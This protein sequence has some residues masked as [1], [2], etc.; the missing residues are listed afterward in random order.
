[1]GL[2][3]A[4][5]GI[6]VSMLFYLLLFTVNSFSYGEGHWAQTEMEYLVS[7]EIIS[8]YPDGSLKPDNPITRA[9]F[10]RIVNRVIG[11]YGTANLSFHDVKETDWFYEDVA[12]AIKAGYV[13]GYGDNTFKPNNPI[14]REE[15]AKIIITAFGL[16]GE[17]PR[18]INSFTDDREIS[19]WAREYV[20]TLR[21]KGYITGYP[22][23]SFKPKNPITRAEAMKIIATVG[24]EIFDAPGTYSKN[25][26]KNALVRTS[27]VVLK[28]MHIKGDLYL[29]IGIGSGEV[30][31]ENVTLEGRVY[32][33]GGSQILIKDSSLRDIVINKV[34]GLVNVILD[35]SQASLVLI[36]EEAKLIAKN[37]TQI[38]SIVAA[39]ESTID[40]ESGARVGRLSIESKG[41]EMRVKGSI[42]SLIANEEF[43]L[44]GQ[45]IVKG[46]KLSIKDGKILGSKKE[47]VVD[48]RRDEYDHRDKKD[49]KDHKD[50]EDDDGKDK[51][52][53]PDY[54][55]I[56]QLDKDEYSINEA[57]TIRGKV[58]KDSI[59]LKDVDITLKLGYVPITVDQ[60]RTDEKGEFALTFLVPEAIEEGEYKLIIKA[61]EPINMVKELDIKLVGVE[62]K[63]EIKAELDKEKYTL[64]ERINLKGQVLEGNIGLANV[65]ITLRLEGY[66]GI[67]LITVGQFKT[68]EDGGFNYSF[69]VPELIESGK[70][71][72]VLKVNEP[73]NRFLQFSMEIIDG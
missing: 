47:A 66:D 37:A 70:Y 57:I 43:I 51:P 54:Q 44:N 8:G 2:C 17:E 7:K 53:P 35:N 49:G 15:V 61:N 72:L 31:L 10:I 18:Q 28:D 25:L 30:I 4:K 73:V 32:I 41:V 19:N 63:Y 50:D 34:H 64:D 60:L 24:G 62:E 42:E 33:T 71:N 23:G 12:K 55:F 48:Q 3:K 29:T 14:S 46:T 68:G 5:R 38:E 1:M 52:I 36:K 67:E 13:E 21:N 59:G 27:D 40:I 22:D 45:R 6:A 11:S 16:E 69:K 56:A 26:D 39:G 65:D 20:T 9:E 58:T